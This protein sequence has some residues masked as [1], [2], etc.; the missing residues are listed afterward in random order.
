M[1]AYLGAFD[2]QS[3][4]QTRIVAAELPT[5]IA[6]IVSVFKRLARRAP[7]IVT[8]ANKLGALYSRRVQFRSIVSPKVVAR[9]KTTLL[10]GIAQ[11]LAAE[12][13]AYAGGAQRREM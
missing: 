8:S 13:A 6:E 11:L 3:R 12:R 1:V 2:G 4:V 5:T 9:P 7:R 10:I